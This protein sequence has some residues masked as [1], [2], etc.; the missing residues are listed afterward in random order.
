MPLFARLNLKRLG[1]VQT[2]REPHEN[3]RRWE[4]ERDLA[5]GAGVPTELWPRRKAG[6]DRDKVAT[7]EG[8]PEG[9]PLGRGRKG[10]RR[11]ARER[12]ALPASYFPLDLTRNFLA[13]PK[14]KNI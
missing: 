13:M 1:F 7:A 10:P 12:E 5:V 6:T 14:V 11:E 9:F 3:Q 8:I 2:V 4:T